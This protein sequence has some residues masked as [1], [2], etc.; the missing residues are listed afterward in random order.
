MFKKGSKE[1]PISI[2]TLDSNTKA[3]IDENL[4]LEEKPSEIAEL[5]QLP[6]DLVY[7]YARLRIKKEERLDVNSGNDIKNMK[8]EIELQTLE[9]KMSMQQQEQNMKLEEHHMRMEER[10]RDMMNQY[11]DYEDDD[12]ISIA[13][14]NIFT[15]IIE[16][17]MLQQDQNTL[18]ANQDPQAQQQTLSPEVS[19]G[20]KDLSDKEIKQLLVDLEKN[21]PKDL[22]VARIYPEEKVIPYIRDRYGL[23]DKTIKRALEILK[24]GK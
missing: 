10:R 3:L 23:T 17:K 9:H 8:A 22:E 21:S 6:V 11:N 14:T 12:P 5:L 1:E 4:D 24:N 18:V 19:V 20:L 7:R 13:L 16:K 2:R 15:P